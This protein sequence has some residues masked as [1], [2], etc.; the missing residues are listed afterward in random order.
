MTEN[1]R[2]LSTILIILVVGL[3]F[4][5]LR[6]IDPGSIG[7]EEISS[8]DIMKHIRFLA[9]DKRAGRYP[10]TRESRDVISY[11][12]N[13]L[14]SYG[15]QPGGESG[16][17]KQTFSILDSVKLGENNSLSVNDKPMNLQEDYVPL[18]FSGNATL[19][20]DIIFAGYGF[21]ILTDSLVWNDY[22][23][24]NIEG[25]W[26]MVM[27]HSP[28][29]DNPHSVYA[30]HSDLHK[31]MIEARDRGAAGILFISQVED[32]TLI[33][34][35]Y[36][37]GYSKSGI[38]AIH[39]SNNVADNI[40]KSVGTSRKIIQEKM[41]RGLET[42][43]FNIPNVNVS[44]N[45]ELKNIYSRAANVIG[46]IVSRNHKYRDEYIVIG[47]HFDH[48]GYGGPGSGSLKPDTNAIHNGANDNASGTA[49]LLELAQILQINRQLL[50][51]SVLLIGF[52]AEEK[53]LIGSK[54]FI[55][56]PTIQ[57][58]NIVTMINMDMIGKMKDSTAMVG[59][60]GTSPIFEPLLDSLSKLSNLKLEY[61]QAGYG[62]SDHASFYAED[63][64]VLFFFTGDFSNNYHLPEDDWEDINAAGEKQILDIIYKS[65][66]ELSRNPIR[67]AFSIA[68]PKTR[69]VQRNNKQVKMGI[70]PYYG[71][72][73]EGLK[74]DKIYDPNGAAA[75][76]G[77]RS[78]DI[79]KSINKKP[80]KDIYEYMKRM[81]EI[82]PGQSIPVDIKRDGKIIML[83]VRF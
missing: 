30:P 42:I 66:I 4:Y 17:F 75:K 34:F 50:K 83:T 36:I 64:P 59:G 44:A 80:I 82:K 21:N 27:R 43:S 72:T 68:G 62:P 81:E 58:N 15:V 25:K 3:C 69:T 47:A 9:D 67:P 54:Y 53:G 63:I 48:L 16:S 22:K 51:R 40:L 20:S 14:K 33:P 45:I 6:Q 77:I 2:I 5:S 60:V 78:G 70:L 1:K 8:D 39:L 41:N 11:L 71:G 55:S 26:V 29:R 38:P 10:G 56:N 49:G 18:W 35:R 46:Q 57:K 24:L 79:I 52:D 12:I 32:T 76:A 7:K 23:D 19:S 74:V 31:K 61:D 73:I 37:S 13:N 65:V 28:E